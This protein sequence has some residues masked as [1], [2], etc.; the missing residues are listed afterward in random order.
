M[1][2]L[3]TFLIVFFDAWDF[4]EVQFFSSVA[5]AFG[6]ITILLGLSPFLLHIPFSD[7]ITTSITVK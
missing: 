1:G 3:F 5:C 2:C 4:D 7:F 6:I